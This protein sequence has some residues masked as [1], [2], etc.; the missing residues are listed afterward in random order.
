MSPPR[1]RRGRALARP[2]C[3]WESASRRRRGGS[4]ADPRYLSTMP[5]QGLL[6]AGDPWIRGDWVSRH[7][8]DIA[9]AARQH[10]ELTVIAVGVGLI[11]SLPLGLIAQRQKW[12]QTPV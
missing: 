8:D 2:P 9:N 3:R 6:A 5:T 7:T 11:L 12:L 10:L 4:W 1:R